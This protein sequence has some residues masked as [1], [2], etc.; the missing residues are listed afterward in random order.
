MSDPITYV[1]FS[2]IVN[3]PNTLAGHHIIDAFTGRF[4]DLT[5]KPTTL[6]G[7]GITD[8]FDGRWENLINRPTLAD[9]SFSGSYN[10]LLNV[11]DFSLVAYSGDYN[12]L[13]NK[14]NINSVVTNPSGGTSGYVLHDKLGNLDYATAG[15]TGFVG[16]S[17]TPVDNQVAV[18]TSATNIEGTT[19]ITWDGTD[20]IVAGN[21]RANGEVLA[22]DGAVPINWWDEMP[23][24]T[25]SSIGGIIWDDTYFEKV[26]NQLTIISGVLAPGGHTHA[27][28]D[29]VSGVP[30]FGSAS[31]ADTSAFLAFDGK[32]VD[33]DKLD[34]QDSTYYAP[35]ASPF[36]TSYVTMDVGILGKTANGY[37]RLYADYDST[38]YLEIDDAPFFAFINA[39]VGI[40][41]TAPSV[42][43]EV[44]GD[45]I[46]TRG[47]AGGTLT[48][49]EATDSARGN[50]FFAGANATGAYIGGS[51]GGSGGTQ[52]LS[53]NSAGGNVGIGTT[54]PDAKLHINN[55]TSNNT[56]RLDTTSAD[57][58][59][60]LTTLTQQDWGI[61]VDFS[62][63]SKF[64][65]DQSTTVGGGTRLTIDTAGNVGIGTT[66]PA[67]K[68]HVYD[69]KPADTVYGVIQNAVY[70]GGTGSVVGLN[71]RF[72]SST[73]MANIY[74]Y[75]GNEYGMPDRLTFAICNAAGDAMVDRM[76]I[77]S[78][79]SITTD[80]GLHV[81]GT[82]DA[83]D[84][85]ILAD[86]SVTAASFKTT[87][88]T[89]E[90]SGTNLLI[91]YGSTTI[92]TIS[93]AGAITAEDEVTAFG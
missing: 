31:L 85:N 76:H 62:D 74:T 84:N 70:T 25:S 42:K 18:W 88:F 83:G 23:W 22:F 28:T 21:I 45:I 93:S 52:N 7:Y 2:S 26:D 33:A 73:R 12:D 47:S 14:P 61:G 10:S 77:A 41:T 20:L 48:L 69:A 89:I 19:G 81:G 36:F 6:L 1:E 66:A 5:D 35:I 79:G 3:M 54:T 9:I 27:W 75:C 40:G 68:L 11:P 15:H 72:H 92:V 60:T 32:A 13:K 29:L 46:T 57:V 17:G 87:N 37:L 78:N 8:A 34:G 4:E 80:G 63:S 16:V 82:S 71:L 24:A 51:Y 86:G 56:L 30:V 43:L 55:A 90:Q 64:K 65:I 67:E 53:I 44:D 39:N 91:K 50:R 38:A 49:F 58:N 59:I